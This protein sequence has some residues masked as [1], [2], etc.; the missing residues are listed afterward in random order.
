MNKSVLS[1]VKA[2]V[3]VTLVVTLL[4]VFLTSCSL[5]RDQTT[6][7]VVAKLPPPEFPTEPELP[8][9][10]VNYKYPLSQ[11]TSP[12]LY[13]YKAKRRLMVV[14]KDMLIRDFRIGLG[15]RPSGDKQHQGDGRTPEG[16]FYVCVKNPNS[17]Y[18]KSLGLSYPGPKHAERALV[19]GNISHQQF[20]RIVQAINSKARPPWDTVLG[21]QIFIHG[22]G[23]NEDWTK[24]CVAIFNTDMDELFE[25]VPVGTP[26]YIMP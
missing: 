20:A 22:G 12:K 24:G 7:T 4:P 6:P 21:G 11:V 19:A 13:V 2:A 8:Y 1:Y 16:E 14:E 23:G 10:E 5:F 9:R 17:A 25:I 15:P 18:Y 3:M 26:V